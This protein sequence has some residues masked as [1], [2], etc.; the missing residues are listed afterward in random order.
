MATVTWVTALWDR[1]RFRTMLTLVSVAVF[2]AGVLAL[3]NSRTSSAT[4]PAQSAA[5][6]APGSPAWQERT[7]GKRIPLPPE[8]VSRA[9]LFIHT[10]VL[11]RSLGVAYSISTAGLHAGMSLGQWDRGVIPVTPL[12]HTGFTMSSLHV[13][14]SRSRSVQME[15]FLASAVDKSTLYIIELVPHGGHWLVG[16]FAPKGVSVP[17]PASQ[18]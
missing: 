7:W 1:P 5:N 17:L 9:K 8:A 10:A 11:R 12:Q 4:A 13:L 6:V 14:H 18:G 15:T 3:V 2:V 16:Y